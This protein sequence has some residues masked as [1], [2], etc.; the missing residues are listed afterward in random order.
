MRVSAPRSIRGAAS[1]TAVFMRATRDSTHGREICS[2][3]HDAASTRL[4]TFG[5]YCAK[6]L[7][8]NS[9]DTGFRRVAGRATHAE[10]RVDGALMYYGNRETSIC[11]IRF[12]TQDREPS[13]VEDQ[14]ALSWHSR[15]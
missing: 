13:R 10:V 8:A 7:E 5:N 9:R 2:R 12:T 1:L 6:G 4:A 14:E 11:W 15:V 3:G